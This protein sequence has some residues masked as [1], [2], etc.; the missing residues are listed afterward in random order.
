MFTVKHNINP[1]LNMIITA[2]IAD[3]FNSSTTMEPGNWI[4]VNITF[5]IVMTVAWKDKRIANT[6]MKAAA[7]VQASVRNSE[8]L[9]SIY[10]SQNMNGIPVK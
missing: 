4:N 1:T 6:Q 8:T 5:N 9:R 10:C 3:N 7:K 2:G